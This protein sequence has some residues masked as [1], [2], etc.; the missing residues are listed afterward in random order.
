MT[1]PQLEWLSRR[2]CELS[3]LDP[4]EDVFVQGW[5]LKR[6]ETVVPQI[7]SHLRMEQALR[8]RREQSDA[9]SV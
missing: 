7:E 6:W 8:E 4:D 9:M 3:G 1:P 5:A 2:Y